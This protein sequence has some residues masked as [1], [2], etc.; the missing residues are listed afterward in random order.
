[1]VS[2][3]QDYAIFLLTPDGVVNSW[4]A[5]AER[6]K[7]YQADEIIG[8][9]FSVFYPA[10]ALERGWPEFELSVA[11]SEGRFE[12][13]G[14]RVRKDGTRFWANVVITAWKDQAGKLL[15]YLKITRDLTERQEAE[16]ALRDS[17]E[18][19]R[20]LVMSVK[21]YAFILIDTEGYVQSW[22]PGAEHIKGYRSEEI[23]GKHFSIF[24][25]REA[26][27]KGWPEQELL[28][29]R[30]RGRFEDEGWRV[31][32]D[33]SQFW[34]NV[35]ITP[36]KTDSGVLRGFWKITRDLTEPKMAED[37]LRRSNK[38]LEQFASIAAHDLQEPLRKVQAFGDRLQTRAGTALD[39]QSRD[40][41]ARMLV[42]ATRMRSL[43]NDLLAFSRVTTK[44][45]PFARVDLAVLVREV[46]TDLEVR[47]QQ[48]GGR[49]DLGL[50]PVLEAD[51]LQMRQLFQ[52]LIANALKFRRPEEPPVITVEST[53]AGS[54]WQ[55][56]V[57]DNGIGFEEKYLDRI[58]EMFQRLHGK[59]EYEGTGMGLAIC[60]K[61][62]E[63]HGGTIT[64]RS[65][66][67]AGATFILKLPVHQHGG[68]DGEENAYRHSNG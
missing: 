7:G 64:A 52:N 36:F 5:G 2:G 65:A 12:D 35:V 14:W 50:L 62:I 39:A 45:Q 30:T 63:R 9:H 34:A 26:I 31:R 28:L 1:M 10:E 43:I 19:F 68:P 53:R 58:F 40:Y 66:P 41:L 56:C 18:R 42:S 33:G 54:W 37:R 11:A 55:I 27:D 20:H 49:V 51:P 67:G 47:I 61:I 22:N 13:E 25:P 3:V 57:R 32:K 4:N 46:I 17:E 23:I 8:K 60:R 44:A 59:D 29:A 48:T 38:E 16:I 21:D 15:G 24:Y 6:I